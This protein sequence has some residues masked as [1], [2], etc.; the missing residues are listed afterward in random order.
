ML[1]KGKLPKWVTEYW[2]KLH[3]I[4]IC[5]LNGMHKEFKRCQIRYIKY[6]VR[7]YKNLVTESSNLQRFFFVCFF[8]LF[9]FFKFYFISLF[10][11]RIS[12]KP[13][14]YWRLLLLYF[15]QLHPRRH[16]V[17]K[18]SLSPS[19]CCRHR[20]QQLL[21]HHYCRLSHSLYYSSHSRKVGHAMYLYFLCFIVIH[22]CLVVIIYAFNYKKW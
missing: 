22:N 8:V 16:L 19:H 5:L 11:L 6:W 17:F 10:L 1:S 18:L 3:I 20:F 15:S 12:P 2:L 14:L 7:C 4:P 13:N 21:L 9:C